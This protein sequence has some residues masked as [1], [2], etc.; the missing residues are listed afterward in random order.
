M[1]YASDI[2]AA[3][4]GL[5]GRVT[6]MTEAFIKARAQKKVYKTTLRELRELSGR[7]LA[8]LGI[9]S[10]EIPYLARKAAYGK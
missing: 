7:E 2:N 6:S 5:R 3:D 4:H 1:A 10:S 8:D 9:S